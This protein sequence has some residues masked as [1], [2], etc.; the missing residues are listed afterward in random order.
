MKQRRNILNPE[1]GKRNGYIMDQQGKNFRNSRQN[2]RN[3]KKVNDGFTK[4]TALKWKQ[5]LELLRNNE[6]SQKGLNTVSYPLAEVL[7]YPLVP[8]EANMV[9]VKD[10]TAERFVPVELAEAA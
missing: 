9:P 1:T 3:L 2:L 5:I 8:V 6:R 4:E 10:W 7:N